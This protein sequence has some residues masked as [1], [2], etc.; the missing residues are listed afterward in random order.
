MDPKDFRGSVYG[1][2]S[3]T[4]GFVLI[5]EAPVL[6]MPAL[7]VLMF[8]TAI[9]VIRSFFGLRDAEN[10]AQVVAHGFG[11]IG[12]DI[13]L[14]QPLRDM[15]EKEVEKGLTT[16]AKFSKIPITSSAESRWWI[17]GKDLVD[18]SW[19]VMGPRGSGKSLTM[20]WM[21][22]EA[23]RAGADILWFDWHHNPDGDQHIDVLPGV[24][25]EDYVMQ[26][27]AEMLGSLDYII[28]LGQE[29]LEGKYGNDLKPIVVF[30]DEFQ[31]ITNTALREPFSIDDQETVNDS[32]RVIQDGF[33]KAK[34]QIVLSVKSIKKNQSGLDMST[35]LQ[36]N[37]LFTGSKGKNFS[38][39]EDKMA[40]FPDE[41][42]ENRSR[43]V[44]QAKAMLKPDEGAQGAVC[45]I[46]GEA[47][48]KRH[49][50]IHALIKML[51]EDQG[52]KVQDDKIEE[53]SSDDAAQF[54]APYMAQIEQGIAGGQSKSKIFDSIPNHGQR[55]KNNP[56]WVWFSEMFDTVKSRL[57][58]VKAA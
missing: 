9:G 33:R 6:A 27:K 20:R 41:I 23:T 25:Y 52:F 44:S 35:L 53:S 51:K 12:Q 16:I 38:A 46:D 32:V 30:W 5:T 4:F 21:A 24:P 55:T 2:L 8:P 48:T 26:S 39:L 45:L 14:G 28:K 1:L 3:C 54:F 43:L 18:V 37:W 58:E 15:D 19:V 17:K 22:R 57:V 40:I 29:R 10:P 47:V 7:F 56:K 36:C 50:D 34:I 31:D 42:A 13:A 11:L 49:P